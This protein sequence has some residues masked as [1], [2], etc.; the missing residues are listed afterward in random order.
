MI[1]AC[2]CECLLLLAREEKLRG[3][4]FTPEEILARK[5]AESPDLRPQRPE[6]APRAKRAAADAFPKIRAA[7]AEGDFEALEGLRDVLDDSLVRTLASEW[8]AGLSW[9]VKDAYAALLM[10]QTAECVQPLFR[11]ALKSP[12]VETRAYALCVLKRDFALFTELMSDGGVDEAK[13]NAAIA[14]AGLL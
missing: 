7:I 8:H 12:T 5:P 6:T 3:R 14:K 13:V 1:R 2:G 10:D 11:D 4:R 9:G